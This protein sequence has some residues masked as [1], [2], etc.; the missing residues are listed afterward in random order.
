MAHALV[1]LSAQEN[2]RRRLRGQRPHRVLVTLLAR[3]QHDQ[4]AV[5]PQEEILVRQQQVQ[6]LL[7]HEPADHAKDRPLEVG[8]EAAALQQFRATSVLPRQ[9][10]H[11]VTRRQQRI[12]AGIPHRHVNPVQQAHNVV[13][14]R[15]HH[16]LEAVAKLRG[17]DF[18]RVPRAHR[19]HP[20]GKQ[21]P[22]LE[23]VG[24]LVIF[25]PVHV[26]E[27]LGEI[28]AGKDAAGKQSLVGDVV[29]R[30]DRLHR[31][32]HAVL[33]LRVPHQQRQQR[34]LPVMAVHH[35][36][37]EL[38]Q[39]QRLDHALAEE[40]EAVRVVLVVALA[41]A[42]GIAPVEEFLAADQVDGEVLAR[43]KHPDVTRE[44]LVPHLD[45]KAQ[46]PFRRRGVPVFQHRAVAGQEDRDLVA[47]VG[48]GARQRGHGI[49]QPARL[50][51]REQ[52]TR[53]VDDF[54][55]ATLDMRLSS[56][57]QRKHSLRAVQLSSHDSSRQ[58][59]RPF[60]RGKLL[61]RKRIRTLPPPRPR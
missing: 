49:R 30:E 53:H 9:V 23:Q 16:A 54:H 44:K 52:F 59:P 5:L 22:A 28:G 1:Q 8:G 57:Q 47:G 13:L 11:R 3:A 38:R 19:R 27:V 51:V 32:R 7:L 42:V 45:F 36:R 2:F 40:N 17:L 21:D 60:A 12:R 37:L 29:D 33:P 58:P 4:P 55:R 41:V 14:A 25:E 46:L 6:S 31:Q 61:A 20:V 50:H 10:C 26:V 43:R 24:L 56:G 48:Q 34:A 39:A 35:V 18:L 15:L